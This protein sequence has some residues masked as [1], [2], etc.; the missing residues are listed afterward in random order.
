MTVL[1]EEGGMKSR[2]LDDQAKAGLAA[3]PVLLMELKASLDT[4]ARHT[5]PT[6]QGHI[7]ATIKKNDGTWGVFCFACTE[8]AH[9]F[10]YPCRLMDL[11][12]ASFWPPAVLIEVPAS[13]E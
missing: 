1:G 3:L 13:G 7:A 12:D 5:A 11:D 10:V 9:E 6:S 2:Q 4:I 8:K